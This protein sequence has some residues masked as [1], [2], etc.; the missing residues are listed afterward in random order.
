MK[1]CCFPP[2]LLLALTSAVIGIL[3]YLRPEAAIKFQ[4]KFYEKI[5]WRLE[6]VSWPK[7]IRN[8]KIMGLFLFVVALATLFLL[9]KRGL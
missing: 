5:N 7:E 1:F 8:T 9:V 6:P 3:L 2:M 4:I